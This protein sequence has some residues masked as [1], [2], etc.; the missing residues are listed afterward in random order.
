M[1][2][3]DYVCDLCGHAFEH[4]QGMT[5]PL[6]RKCPSCGKSG[7]RRLIGAGAGVLFKGTGFYETDYKR[8]SASGGKPPAEGATDKPPATV[9]GKPA[10]TMAITS[11]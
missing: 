11:T 4:F 10:L 8:K 2:T 9:P 7:L 5:E 3:Y 6:L 1:P